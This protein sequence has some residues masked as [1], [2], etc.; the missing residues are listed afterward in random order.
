M[1]QDKA[2]LSNYG[3]RTEELDP[4]QAK[5]SKDGKKVKKKEIEPQLKL[6]TL[7]N[8]TDDK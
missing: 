2:Q 8:K 3:V 4:L 7:L 5:K 1:R 6:E